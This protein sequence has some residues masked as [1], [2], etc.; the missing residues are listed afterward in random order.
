MSA[1]TL[2]P[3]VAVARPAATPYRLTSRRVLAS[4]WLKQRTL[5]STVY[6]LVGMFV[7]LAGFGLIAAQI[8]TGS[9]RS[10][11]NGPD[12]SGTSP[13]LTV[14]SGA[15]FAILIVAV[16][17][18]LLGAREYSS[19]MIRSTLAA[20][21]SRL[22]VLWAK[23]VSF[24]G[25]VG[26]VVFVGTLIAF[27]GGMALLGHAGATTASWSDPGVARAVL[28]TAAYLVGLG[29]IGICLGMILRS[30]GSGLG[31]LIGGL[32][33]LPTLASALLP[34]S[35]DSVLKYLPSNAADSFTS[36]TAT[37]GMLSATAGAWVFAG[38]VVLAL[39][40]A[41][42]ALKRRDV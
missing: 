1:A 29:V 19:G 8:S 20:V 6:T 13:V 33:F 39:A 23:V 5:K 36:V 11:G 15:N 41:A 14:L 12:F 18:V 7:V 38:W 42:V 34:S 9:T 17:G 37:D 2:N 21:P 27:F 30:I 26:P 28:G 16:L 40:A 24:V 32:L 31:V 3:D 22:P 25:L 4:E 10:A 35:W